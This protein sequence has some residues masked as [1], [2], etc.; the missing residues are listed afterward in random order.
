[1]VEDLN[2]DEVKQLVNFYRQKA[3]DLE[4]QILQIQLKNARSTNLEQDSIPATK[5][6]KTKSDS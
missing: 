2:I 4:L 6:T 3:S 1:V 5:I